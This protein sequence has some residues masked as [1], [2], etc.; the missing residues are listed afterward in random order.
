MYIY[1]RGGS[2]IL[3]RF[4]NG[5]GERERERGEGERASALARNN[6]PYKLDRQGEP[7]EA[8]E[9]ARR[10][11]SRAEKC[12]CEGESGGAEPRVGE[13]IAFY[14]VYNNCKR[15]GGGGEEGE[16]E[17]ECDLFCP[18]IFKFVKTRN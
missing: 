15:K 10:R 4:G 14:A 16:R 1:V 6:L 5:E 8:R 13:R 7:R 12:N 3:P 18:Y 9:K 11:R 17:R 2:V